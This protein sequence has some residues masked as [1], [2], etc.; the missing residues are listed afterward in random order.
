MKKCPNCKANTIPNSWLLFNKSNSDTKH[1]YRCPNCNANIK[2]S[3]SIFNLILIPLL[4]LDIVSVFILLVP[5]ALVYQYTN[6]VFL[7]ITTAFIIIL[8]LYFASKYFVKLSVAT[9]DYCKYGVGKVKAVIDFIIMVTLI[10]I[11]L[12]IILAPLFS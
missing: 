10:L 2:K 9:D 11:T 6:S 12:F 1:C 3:F 5:I 4:S 8:T 7:S